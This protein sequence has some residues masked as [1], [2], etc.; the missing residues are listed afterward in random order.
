MDSK[1]FRKNRAQE[2]SNVT[3][4]GMGVN[5]VL[6]FLKLVAGI[7]S[8]SRVLVADAVHSLSDLAS[9][10]V[11]LVGMHYWQKPRDKNHPYGHGRIEQ[12]V[13]LFLGLSLLA[14]GGG[15]V[16]RAVVTLNDGQAYTHPQIAL[17]AAAL[18]ILFK[19]WIFRKTYKI[20]KAANSSAVIAN[21]WHHRTDAISSIPAFISIAVI[22]WKPE[23]RIIDNVGAVVVAV[24]IMNAAVKIIFPNIG[25]LVDA[26]VEASV[27]ADLLEHV[28]AVKGVFRA[29]AMR[30]RQLGADY[31]MDLHIEV[32]PDIT[33]R[34]GH[35]I[36]EMVSLEVKRNHPEVIDVLVHVEPLGDTDD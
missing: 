30:V 10:I 18:S 27:K 1:V 34:E 12:I 29:H 7:I 31:A 21:A 14:T 23:W 13:S 35:A 33:V 15:I 36:A 8:S 19:E 6:V 24:I 5:L 25:K 11:L 9:D 3:K 22:M 17:A 16:W 32:S 26:G 28:E 4:L 20:G 2:I